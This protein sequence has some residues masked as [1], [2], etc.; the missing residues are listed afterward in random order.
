MSPQTTIKFV[1]GLHLRGEQA[2]VACRDAGEFMRSFLFAALTC[3]LAFGADLQE[4]VAQ[5]S[6]PLRVTITVGAGH[7][8]HV[9]DDRTSFRSSDYQQNG[10]LTSF[11][12]VPPV[13]SHIDYTSITESTSTSYASLEESILNGSLALEGTLARFGA[14]Q[15][16]LQ[17]G[18]SGVLYR[19]SR[20]SNSQSMQFDSF[21]AN[22]FSN[23]YTESTSTFQNSFNSSSSFFSDPDHLV[24]LTGQLA[25][26]ALDPATGYLGPAFNRG[27]NGDFDFMSFGAAGGLFANAFGFDVNVAGSAGYLTGQDEFRGGFVMSSLQ[28]FLNRDLALTASAGY[29][30]GKIFESSEPRTNSY[31]FELNERFYSGETSFRDSRTLEL[32]KL[33]LEAALSWKVP[34]SALSL[35]GYAGWTRVSGTDVLNDLGTGT[36][37]ESEVVYY[38]YLQNFRY[39]SRTTTDLDQG[40]WRFGARITMP[41]GAGTDSSLL[42]LSRSHTPN[43]GVGDAQRLNPFWSRKCSNDDGGRVGSR[44]DAL[45]V[46]CNGD[47]SDI[48]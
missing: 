48:N 41:L 35:T 45:Q 23:K 37:S 1:I 31:N 14:V 7:S 39:T 4:V 30:R 40:S 13:V 10:A 5:D 38:S 27:S 24:G 17:A 44:L 20:I 47:N 36:G 2:L 8:P 3:A 12:P 6:S 19:P 33:D 29:G 9:S 21:G 32:D 42:A 43:M 28:I 26:Y 34:N 15:M 11:G 22:K 16:R 25:I 46:V 18:S